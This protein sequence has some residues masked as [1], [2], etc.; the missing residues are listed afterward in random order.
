M[1][2]E[3]GENIFLPDLRLP[4]PP[5]SLQRKQHQSNMVSM[6]VCAGK[7]RAFI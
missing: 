4:E 5:Q 6:S 7:V 3:A 1:K 2:T